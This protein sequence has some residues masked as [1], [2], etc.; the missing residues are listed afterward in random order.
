MRT[1]I[2]LSALV[3]VLFLMGGAVYDTVQGPMEGKAAIGQLA[4]SDTQY[5][6]SRA[7]ALGAVK[8]V[9]G[10]SALAL[11]AIIWLPALCRRHNSATAKL[12]AVISLAGLATTGCMGPY[13]KELVEEIAPNETAFL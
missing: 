8:K 1:R 6:A 3:V 2:I 10:L 12:V 11:I 7:I 4:D 13:Q 5:A 9:M